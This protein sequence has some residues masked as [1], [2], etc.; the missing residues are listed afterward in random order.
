MEEHISP[1][2]SR[3]LTLIFL[4]YGFLNPFRMKV[5]WGFFFAFEKRK[6]VFFNFG[7]VM[8][9]HACLPG[10]SSCVTLSEFCVTY[11]PLP[12]KGAW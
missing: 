11:F 1:S 5:F 4:Y 2:S 3:L 6:S 7:I 12:V 9:S 10:F 8:M